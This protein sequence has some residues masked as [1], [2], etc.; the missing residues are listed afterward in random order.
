M[1]W[2]VSIDLLQKSVM[3]QFKVIDPGD[4]VESQAKA[5]TPIAVGTRQYP[6]DL[7]AADDMLDLDPQPG[8]DAVN[9]ELQ[10]L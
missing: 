5:S 2:I 4:E 9:G 1:L 7:E 6:E 3:I 10:R 8:L